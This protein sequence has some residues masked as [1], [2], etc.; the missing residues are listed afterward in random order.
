[1]GKNCKGGKRRISFTSPS[2]S[3]KSTTVEVAVHE[4][5]STAVPC[6]NWFVGGHAFYS[7]GAYKLYEE[8]KH[9]VKRTTIYGLCDDGCEEAKLRLC[10]PEHLAPVFLMWPS[11]SFVVN[12][13]NAEEPEVPLMDGSALPFFSK[14]RRETGVPEEL[15]FY[16]VP[17]RAE[18]ELVR[19][20]S[21]YGSVRMEPSEAFEVEYKMTSVDSN[22]SVSVYSAEDLYTLFMARTFITEAEYSAAR[23]SGLLEGVN[24]TC[25]LLLSGSGS[26][27]G[28]FR[29]RSEPAMHKILDLI[30]DLAF[31]CPSLPKVRIEILNGGHVAHH[32][33]VEKLLPY[34]SLNIAPEV[35]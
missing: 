25:G 2:L 5:N 6:V 18:W 12:L 29:V 20:G 1:M 19:D 16:E 32:Q 11:R 3:F 28:K 31:V 21:A 9:S 33:I 7:T 23:K 34:V 27:G 15:S 13:L 17:V 24:E 22:A 26:D 14:I 4:R 8:L 10:S 30:G 35:R